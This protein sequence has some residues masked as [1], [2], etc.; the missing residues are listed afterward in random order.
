MK[1]ETHLSKTMITSLWAAQIL[2]AVLLVMGAIMK[3]LPIEKIST[4]MPWTGQIPATF[5]RLLGIIDLLGAV[6]L[7]LPTSLQIKP[8]LTFWTALCIIALMLSA[9]IFHIFRGE[10]EAIGINIFSMIM[11]A[12]IAWGRFKKRTM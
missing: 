2:L 9:I 6:G 1:K 8:Q 5:V 10:A 7:I 11:A 12:F 4:M 3:F